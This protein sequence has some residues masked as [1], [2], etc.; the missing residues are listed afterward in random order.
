MRG[1]ENSLNIISPNYVTLEINSKEYIWCVS[2]RKILLRILT[3][4]EIDSGHILYR[5]FN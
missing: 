1:F 3:D 4:D 2:F 5:S